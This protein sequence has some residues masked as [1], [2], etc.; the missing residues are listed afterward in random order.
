MNNLA[1]GTG[2]KLLE[3]LKVEERNVSR[4]VTEADLD[5]SSVYALG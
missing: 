4:G 1:E 3:M 5:F 2:K